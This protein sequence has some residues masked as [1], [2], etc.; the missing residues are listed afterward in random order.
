[1]SN[2]H[3]LLNQVKTLLKIYEK[4]TE[5]TGENFNIFRIMNM[6]RDE[7]STHSVIIAEL[8]NPKGSHG[9]GNK[10]LEL[11]IG[12]NLVNKQDFLFDCDSAN[13]YKE[14]YIGKINEEGTQGGRIDL[15]LKDKNR[16]VIVIENKIDAPE[17]ENQLGRYKKEYPKSE[18]FYLTLYGEESKFYSNGDESESQQVFEYHKI[19]YKEHILKWIEACTKEAFNI[20]MVREMLNQYAILIRKLTNQ[21]TNKEMEEETQRLIRENYKES[22]EIYRNFETSRRS[23]IDDFFDELLNKSKNRGHL[24]DWNLT[25]DNGDVFS[26]KIFKTL[27]ISNDDKSSKL[28]FYLRYRLQNDEILMGIV[29]ADKSLKPKELLEA[30]GKSELKYGQRSVIYENMKDLNT[31]NIIIDY[32]NKDSEN[33]FN[34][35]FEVMKSYMKKNKELYNDLKRFN[36]K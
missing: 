33:L 18:L 6:E 11:F 35:I 4:H 17:Q 19:S 15:V 27:L 8:L 16:N 5:L 22:L 10:P 13:C 28:F 32:L 14:F 20:P 29:H 23:I 34:N 1:M 7:V 24:K 31:Q 25:I 21:S 36:K 2:T 9:L 12:Y 3:Y 26:T 30:S